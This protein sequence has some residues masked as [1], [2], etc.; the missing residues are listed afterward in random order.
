MNSVINNTVELSCKVDIAFRHFVSNALLESW[1]TSLADVEPLLHGKYELFWVPEDRENNSTI[2]CKITVIE[3]N[4]VLAFE[5]K[6]PEQFKHFT[7]SVD[8]LTHVVVSFIPTETGTKV[9]LIHS[10]WRTTAGW[11]EAKLWQERAW[12]LAFNNL[13]EIIP[14]SA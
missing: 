13:K 5:W 11:Q 1:L 6:S 8:P 9:S 10:G 4:S 2:G 3:K 14:A 7:N 12:A